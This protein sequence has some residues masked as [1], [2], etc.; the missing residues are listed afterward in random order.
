MIHNGALP[1]HLLQTVEVCRQHRLLTIAVV[2]AALQFEIMLL[3]LVLP[4]VVLSLVP[5]MP[6]H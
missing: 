2:D 4:R 5:R 1:P 6:L 3:S